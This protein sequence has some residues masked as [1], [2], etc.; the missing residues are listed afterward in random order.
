[1]VMNRLTRTFAAVRAVEFA[2][3]EFSDSDVFYF[4]SFVIFLFIYLALFVMDCYQCV[5]IVAELTHKWLSFSIL[6]ALDWGRGGS[7]IFSPVRPGPQPVNRPP[8]GEVTGTRPTE[9]TF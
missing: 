6:V 2:F 7:W 9:S 8:R 4:I 5:C 1:M 3:W